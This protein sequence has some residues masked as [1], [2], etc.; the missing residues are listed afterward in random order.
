M[1]DLATK[2]DLHAV[3]RIFELRV[4]LMLFLMTVA[5]AL[6]VTLALVR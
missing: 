5:L 4:A 2:E 1:K 6:V 3:L